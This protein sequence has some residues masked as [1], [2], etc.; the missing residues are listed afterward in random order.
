MH[1]LSKAFILFLVL[2]IL[3]E[4]SQAILCSQLYRSTS[5]DYLAQM[6][7]QKELRESWPSLFQSDRLAESWHIDEKSADFIGA[8]SRQVIKSLP[9]DVQKAVRHYAKIYPDKPGGQFDGINGYLREFIKDK[10][11]TNRS[12][13]PS[14]Y[15]SFVARTANAIEHG[16]WESPLLPK[17]LIL[18]R[19]MTIDDPAIIQEKQTFKDFGFLSTSLEPRVAYEFAQVTAT[20]VGGIPHLFIIEI[21]STGIHG[22]HLSETNE[23]EILLQRGLTM[24]VEHIS[25]RTMPIRMRTKVSKILFRVVHLSIN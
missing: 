22:L 19:G 18:F 21:R 5:Y 17:G 9:P 12:I 20:R 3:S 2:I 25:E 1:S 15:S 24:R 13:K 23:H 4:R 11:L 14:M 8:Q 6:D 7:A 16:I 10:Q